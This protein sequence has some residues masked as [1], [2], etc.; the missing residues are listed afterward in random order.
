MAPQASPSPP[1]RT[2]AVIAARGGSEGIPRKNLIDLCGKP[3]LAWTIEQAKGR[4]R[5]R[6][7]RRLL[8]QR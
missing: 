1:P 8:R 6:P 3:L 5:R 7:R 4:R 2:L